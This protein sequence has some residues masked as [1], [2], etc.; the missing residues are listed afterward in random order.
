MV[1]TN[2]YIKKIKQVRLPLSE[3]ALKKKQ[4]MDALGAGEARLL[5]VD[6]SSSSRPKRVSFKETHSP[7]SRAKGSLEDSLSEAQQPVVSKQ[8]PHKSVM[9]HLPSSGYDPG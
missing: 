5:A 3:A 6:A 2:T 9:I 1:A 4:L 8:K 7:G